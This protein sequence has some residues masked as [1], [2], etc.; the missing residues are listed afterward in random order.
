M[1]EHDR[2]TART[3]HGPRARGAPADRRRSAGAEAVARQAR[4][5]RC[6][7]SRSAAAGSSRVDL[8]SD[9]ERLRRPDLAILDG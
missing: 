9:P 8:L 6:R 7:A 3:R 4:P 5:S 1:D 2:L